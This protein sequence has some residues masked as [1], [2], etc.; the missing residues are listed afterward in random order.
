MIEQS[1]TSNIPISKFDAIYQSTNSHWKGNQRVPLNFEPFKNL[2]S[3]L[4]ASKHQ[5]ITFQHHRLLLEEM[6]LLPEDAE[7]TCTISSEHYF[8][9]HDPTV[10]KIC[11]CLEIE[12]TQP[13]IIDRKVYFSFNLTVLSN[14]KLNEFKLGTMHNQSEVIQEC[15]KGGGC[16]LNCIID[17]T[18]KNLLIKFHHLIDHPSEILFWSSTHANLRMTVI[19]KKMKSFRNDMERLPFITMH[20]LHEYYGNPT[21]TVQIINHLHTHVK[22]S[23]ATAVDTVVKM[24]EVSTAKLVNELELNAS[25]T[26]F[27]NF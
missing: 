11:C 10:S 25:D 9:K 19:K 26:N 1:S 12:P 17:A 15:T 18:G 13:Y 27:E 5:P 23:E 3:N 22:N 20:F 14:P 7:F 24:A 6:M 16:G 2:S 8:L 4:M 21:P